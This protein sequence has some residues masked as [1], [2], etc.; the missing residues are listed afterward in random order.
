MG[1]SEKSGI[2]QSYKFSKRIQ[3]DECGYF[4]FVPIVREVCGTYSEGPFKNGQCN[5]DLN[6]GN[7]CVEELVGFD[8]NDNIMDWRSIRGIVV[9]VYVDCLTLQPLPD[10]KQDVAWTQPGVRLPRDN[11]LAA[12]YENFWNQSVQVNMAS[13]NDQATCSRETVANASDCTVAA[14]ALLENG[15]SLVST[16]NAKDGKGHTVAVSVIYA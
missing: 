2:S 14:Q 1:Y 7:A 4:T 12:A 10:E 13:Q 15:D 6:I 5:N 11:D 3:D 9:F 16:H 8:T